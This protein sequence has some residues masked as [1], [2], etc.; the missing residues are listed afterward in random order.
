MR[1]IYKLIIC[2]VFKSRL[3]ESQKIKFLSPIVNYQRYIDYCKRYNTNISYNHHITFLD[4]G[5]DEIKYMILIGYYQ[6]FLCAIKKHPI[7]NHYDIPTPSNQIFQVL[8][9]AIDT[10]ACG[11]V[12]Q[13]QTMIA[14]AID[15]NNIV[16]LDKCLHHKLSK[17]IDYN[18]F[19]TDDIC[20]STK[21]F[22]CSVRYYPLIDYRIIKY[23]LSKH[24]ITMTSRHLFNASSKGD[25]EMVKLL[26][27]IGTS[28][29]PKGCR[30]QSK[31]I[32]LDTPLK[33]ILL[34]K[35]FLF[36]SSFILIT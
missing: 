10:V 24:K 9:D 8:I 22:I 12:R 15:T 5:F 1:E 29:A 36:I 31:K 13:L 33:I 28:Q 27:S 16:Q 2:R 6:G 7:N 4:P 21:Y 14:C 25:V 3:N 11:G 32:S 20:L 30:K 23:L 19:I 17:H 26:L 34:L 18:D 35:L